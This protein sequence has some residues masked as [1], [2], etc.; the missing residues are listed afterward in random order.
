M[1]VS[2]GREAPQLPSQLQLY[3]YEPLHLPEDLQLKI[4][5]M[6]QGNIHPTQGWASVNPLVAQ[7][8]REVNH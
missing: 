3:H 1:R 4:H 2:W 6:Y 7:S 5:Q 8:S